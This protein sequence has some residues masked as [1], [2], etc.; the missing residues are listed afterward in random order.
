M[1]LLQVAVRLAALALILPVTTVA[2]LAEVEPGSRI[3]FVAPA[4]FGAPVT[5]IVLERHGD[6]LRIFPTR[7]ATFDMTLGEMAAVRIS[8]GKSRMLGA[9]V[10]ALWG[11]GIYAVLGASVALSQCSDCEYQVDPL[12]AT[13][14]F[15][16]SGAMA[17]ATI[18]LIMGRE[19][20][21][22]LTSVA[23]GSVG[24]RRGRWEVGLSFP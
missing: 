24:F 12:E 6:T 10:G 11:A 13:A 9:S 18:G 23:R 16:M 2:Q 7:G 5:G 17:G 15:A 4:R 14:A 22:T 3:R 21:E 19:R 20:W 1:R 8:R